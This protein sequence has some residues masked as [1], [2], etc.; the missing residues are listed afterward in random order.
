MG[1]D[2][3]VK[4]L[5]GITSLLLAGALAAG[6]TRDSSGAASTAGASTAGQTPITQAPTATAPPIGAWYRG[7]LHSHSATYSEDARR[8]GGDPIDVTVRVAE[9]VGLD[10]L[11]GTDHRSNA[12]VTDPNF[13]SS[14]LVCLPGMEWG[15]SMHAGAIGLTRPIQPN[16]TTSGALLTAEIDT[17]IADVHQQGGVFVLNHPVEGMWAVDPVAFDAVEVWNGMWSLQTFAP[18]TQQ[19]L[20]AQMTGLGLTQAGVPPSPHAVAAVADQR[21]SSSLQAVTLWESYLDSGRRV[22]AVGGG[23]R[24]MLRP[25]G[26]PTTHVYA[27]SRDRKG[28]LDG[29]RAARTFVSR[30]PQGPLVAFSADADRDGVFEALVGDEVVAGRPADFRV[31]VEGAQGGRVDVI[32]RGAVIRSEAV[33]SSTHA[34]TFS[35]TPAAGDWYRVDVYEAIDPA[36]VAR[37]GLA[38]K[39]AQQSGKEWTILAALLAMAPSSAYD[40]SWGTLLPTLILPDQVDRLAN[41]S[42]KDPGFCRG[43]ITSAIYTR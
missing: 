25:Q 2:T 37:E 17:I 5:A 20:D 24:H 21:G 11:A 10:F 39:L 13:S 43:A 7:D 42:I 4:A 27:A 30:T 6:C 34:L 28:I 35:D 19:D 1:L 23:D 14:Q 38:L 31:V 3:T 40:T 32:K 41:A 33:T 26:Y 12:V 8:Q 15:G 9:R 29:I 22:A 36:V 16:T 18:L